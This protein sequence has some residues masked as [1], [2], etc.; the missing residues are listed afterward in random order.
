VIDFHCHLDLYPDPVDVAD[1][2]VADGV[3]VLSVTTA[4]SAWQTSRELLERK[5]RVRVALGLH[6]QI[7]HERAGEVGIFESQIS[8]TKYIG[9]IGLDGGPEYGK[10]RQLQADL[11]ARLMTI[12]AA[13]GGR[14]ISL[15][16][17][18]AAD[19]V[20]DAIER[21]PKAGTPILHWFSGT[22]DELDRAIRLGCWFSVGPA[23]LVSKKGRML[24]SRMPHDRILTETDGPFAKFED[25]TLYPW[26]VHGAVESLSRIW[27]MP[28]EE[29]EDIL[30]SNLRSLVSGG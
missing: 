30:S 3:Y 1:R 19:A 2:C 29:T 24:A 10:Y 27:I 18:H 13:S 4:P 21:E 16:S 22:A 6:P 20:L 25:A 28:V 14:I 5:G 17:R 11:F 26:Q 9:E 12:C 8:N 23:M 15:H 7:A